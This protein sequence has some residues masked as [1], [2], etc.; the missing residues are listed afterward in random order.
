[1]K[2]GTVKINDIAFDV[3]IAVTE[4]EKFKGLSNTD[5]LPQ[6]KGM[7]F[8]FKEPQEVFFVMRDMNYGLDIIFIDTD[9]NIIKIK[10]VGK[11]YK[12]DI[13]SKVKIKAVLELNKGA[14]YD[15]DIGDKALL[16]CDSKVELTKEQK[17]ALTKRAIETIKS[18]KGG[19]ELTRNPDKAVK[20]GDI[21]YDGI[22]ASENVGE[23]TE[24]G[25]YV[26]DDKTKKAYYKIKGGER[27]VAITDTSDL[28]KKALAVQ[29]GTAKASELGKVL[30]DIYNRQDNQEAQFVSAGKKGFVFKLR[31]DK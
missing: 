16:S 30:V 1:M 9:S 20:V 26:I 14:S 22:I 10:S 5:G 2:K 29:E 4:E 11:D 28:F 12:G 17:D 27:V 31:K 13:K 21:V 18:F 3:D 23:L 15:F 25:F 24:D 8:L 6:G 7:L 19:G